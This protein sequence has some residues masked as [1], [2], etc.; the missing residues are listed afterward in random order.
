MA[1]QRK[2]KAQSTLEYLLLLTGVLVIMIAFL[3]PGGFF[4]QRYNAAFD[5]ATNGMVNMADRLG[6]SRYKSKS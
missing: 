5:S 6:G 4:S 3:R 2:K 1:K